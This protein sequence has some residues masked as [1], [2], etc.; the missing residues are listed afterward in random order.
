MPF[1]ASISAGFGANIIN[2]ISSVLD[3][4]QHA[5]LTSSNNSGNDKFGEKVAIDGNIAV[6][7]APNYD[8]SG[9]ISSPKGAAYVFTRSGDTWTQ[10]AMIQSND[11]AVGDTFGHSVAISGNTII[12]GAKYEDGATASVTNYGAVYVFTGSGS[13]WTQQA[14]LLDPNPSTNDWFGSTGIAIDGDTI[15][16][17]SQY[18]DDT[19]QNSGTA[20]IFTR[21]GSAWTYRTQLEAS[22]AAANDKFGASVAIDGNTLLV[23]AYTEGGSGTNRGAVY[24]F[25][26]SGSSWSQQAKLTASDAQDNDFFGYGVDIDGDTAVIGAFGED[27]ILS[28]TGSAYVFNRSGSS[29]SQQQKLTASNTGSNFDIGLSVAIEGSLIALGARGADSDTGAVYVFKLDGGTWTEEQKL[30]SDEGAE[31]DELGE[32]ISFSSNYLIA[33]TKDE[34]A[35]IFKYTNPTYIITPSSTNVN[36]G[37]SLTVNIATTNVAD[38]TTLY[39]T[40]TNSGDFAT[41][42]GSFTITSDAGSFTV[43]PTSDNT[44]EGNETF[45]VEIRTDSTS[46]T[47]VAQTTNITIVDTSTTP[48]PSVDTV[49]GPASVNEGSAATINVATSNIPNGTTLNWSVSRAGDF[50]TSSGTVTINSNAGSF[51]VTPTADT[52]TEGSETFTVT[53]SGTVSSTS[54]STTSSNITINDTSGSPLS[55]ASPASGPKLLASD[56]ETSDNFGQSVSISNNGTIAIVGAPN[57]DTGGT[58]TGAAYI[59]SISGSTWTQQAKIQASDK[60][61]YDAFGYSVSID[62]DGDTAIVGAYADDTT[63][64]DTGSAYIFTRSGI[65]WSQQAKIYAS[66]KANSDYFGRGVSISGDGNTVVVS[67]HLEDPIG[68]SVANQ[69]AGSA[70]I[71]T[72]SGTSWSQQAKIQASDAQGSDNFGQS[73]DIS[74]DG[75]TVI[76]GAYNEDTGGTNAGAA[77]I[78]TRSGST[79]TQQA[80]IQASNAGS[81]D[82]FGQ[83]VSIDSDGD[84]AIVGAAFE[85]TGGSS[86]GSAYIFTRS[87]TS[88]SQQAQ[89]QPT[90]VSASD[91]FGRSVSISGDGN[92]VI[93]SSY[94]E[95]TGFTNA[96]AVYIFTRSG[97]TWTQQSKIQAYDAQ[98]SAYFGQLVNISNDG[99]TAIIGANNTDSGSISAAGAA[100]IYKPS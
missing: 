79:W 76:V 8:T 94:V 61:S 34:S 31:N 70:Y 26:G 24:V 45:I 49:T 17:G 99:N 33:S 73:V 44:T 35:F 65:S 90:N 68:T 47:V 46:G 27:N 20:H 53:V 77:Y 22:D 67:A 14:K 1:L 85:D 66:D 43:T 42:S 37:S 86:A 52:T 51:S 36:E 32:R 50:S 95:D 39:W 23:S 98:A 38:A 15:A 81:S 83:S 16:I 13:T 10:Q 40:A 72:R 80:K 63:Y 75:D 56:A 3:W 21:S 92:T 48:V 4:I 57:E 60:A 30:I 29:W 18:S 87:G 11:I 69:D 93:G 28:N 7:G 82:R 59:Y 71:F 78:Y 58:S 91:L 25:T 19:A 89:I 41:S 9:G 6:V 62:S 55:W 96:G 74:N 64:T 12:V 54:V 88:W 5:K 97:S 2:S 84:T 100:Y